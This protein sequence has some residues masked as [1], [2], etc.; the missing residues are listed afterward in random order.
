MRKI[1]FG[2]ILLI[3]LGIINIFP[4]WIIFK[5]AI[6]SEKESLLWPPTFLPHSVNFEN[7]FMFFKTGETLKALGLSLFV[8]LGTG[9][10]SMVVGSLSG[11]AMAREPKVGSKVSMFLII[12]RMFPMVAIAIPLAVIF[13]KIGLYN[14]P[15]GIGLIFAHS[16]LV[17]PFVSLI[18]YS[19]FKSIPVALEEQA[20]IDGCSLIGTFLKVTLP[21]AAPGIASSFIIAF[22]LS[23]NEFGYSLLLQV[24]HRNLSPLL[25][26]YTTFGSTGIA[27]ALSLI[28]ILPAVFILLF[29]QRN[30]ASE[31]L[32]SFIK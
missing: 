19:T 6:T 22:I 4:L 10:I 30:I 23:W 14:H 31:S 2:L 17:L 1:R 21:L 18:L 8:S 20:Q 3:L 12:A 5:Q 25:Y 9:L 13:I 28:M 32:A 15:Y 29:F 11:W 16:I 24:T 27:S 26:Y 7:I